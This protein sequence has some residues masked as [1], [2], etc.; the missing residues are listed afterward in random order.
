MVDAETFK[1]FEEWLYDGSGSGV[2]VS[3]PTVRRVGGDHDRGFSP[4]LNAEMRHR[5]RHRH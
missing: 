3:F 1:E 2:D 5:A 4:A